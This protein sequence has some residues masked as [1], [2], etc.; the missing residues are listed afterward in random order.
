MVQTL[1]QEAVKKQLTPSKTVKRRLGK[2]LA[3]IISQPLRHLTFDVMVRSYVT[4]N[5]WLL[6]LLAISQDS[7]CR[8]IIVQRYVLVPR[9]L[10][11]LRALSRIGRIGSN[12]SRL[13]SQ[14]YLCLIYRI[15]KKKKIMNSFLDQR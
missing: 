4:L 12:G 7:K 15:M 2:D 14:G 13:I 9:G 6:S 5:S 11:G 8:R 1:K 3:S 10:V